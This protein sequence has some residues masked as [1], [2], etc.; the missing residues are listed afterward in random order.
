MRKRYILL[1]LMLSLCSHEVMAEEMVSDVTEDCSLND[2][3]LTDEQAD[4]VII[5]NQQKIIGNRQ[6]M[7]YNFR[8][9][10]SYA[11]IPLF[12][13]SFAMKG[14][15][16]G[17]RSARFG[18]AKDFKTSIDNYLQYSP[19]VA[20]LGCKL[21]GYQGRSDW[22]RFA[23]S[24]AFSNIAM[25]AIV[26]T[27]KY[28]VKEKRPDNSSRNSFP[29]GHT[30]TVFTAA[31]ILHKE[32]GLT[33]SPWFSVGG[34]AIATTTGVMRVLNNRHWVSDVIAGA[35]IGILSTELGY[36]AA[37][38]IFKNKGVRHYE[39]DNLDDSEHPSFFDI[40]MGVG[41][42][43]NHITFETSGEPSANDNVRLGTST[44][45]GVET[46]YFLNKNWGV[47][48]MGR[49]T[50]TPAKDLTMNGK[51]KNDGYFNHASFDAGAYY[52]LPVGERFSFGAK[53]LLGTRLCDG[54]FYDVDDE[55]A[56]I[57]NSVTE[58]GSE[59]GGCLDVKGSTAFNYVLGVN[60]TWQYK[61]NFAWKVF[62]DFDSARSKYTLL[63]DYYSKTSNQM[64]NLF[65]FGGSFSI[66]F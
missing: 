59:N 60:M 25:A 39:I 42:H 63:S 37:D 1:L 28:T 61:S 40:Q 34:Y 46:A 52:N 29:S 24:T 7:Y 55:I 3:L 14:S 10:M 23:V 2:T 16:T 58:K 65:T 12:L 43:K 35:G 57:E 6:K 54:I 26:N 22:G 27:V 18:Y 48:I 11:G 51:D 56:K 15:K 9:D 41:V 66:H 64:F 53:A 44:T 45:F 19:Y 20:V 4:S 36:F 17:F 38:L 5:N 13:S 32:Y 33:R 31:T 62:A 21:A 30:A 47:G 50:T 8:R 49:V